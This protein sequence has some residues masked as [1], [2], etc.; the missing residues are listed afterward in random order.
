MQARSIFFLKWGG[1]MEGA[2]LPK[3]L[4]SKEKKP[5]NN[6]ITNIHNPYPRGE[7]VGGYRNLYFK[8]RFVNFPIIFYV[9]SQ[10]GGR[11]SFLLLIS[12]FLM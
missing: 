12:I 11:D 8:V 3:I 1:G 10:K 7:G 6:F 4:T 9:L 5:T 2:D